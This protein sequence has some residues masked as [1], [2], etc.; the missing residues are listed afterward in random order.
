VKKPFKI[1][2]IFRSGRQSGDL[3]KK[4]HFI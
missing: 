2:I 3:R 1:K 4:A